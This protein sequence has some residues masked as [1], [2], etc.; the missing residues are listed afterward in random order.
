MIKK[1]YR[2]NVVILDDSDSIYYYQNLTFDPSFR[3]GVAGQSSTVAFLNRNYDVGMFRLLK[4]RL[5]I[6]HTGL[7]VGLHT[8]L[9][10]PFSEKIS[11]LKQGGFFEY[12][13]SFWILPRYLNPEVPKDLPEVLTMDHL[14]IGFYICC[15]PLFSAMISFVFETQI[16]VRAS[17]ASY[18]VLKNSVKII[19]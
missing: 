9:V 10:E 11:K 8:V 13:I 19:N 5:I 4:E 15:I 7:D 18:Y 2:A 12:W 14:A 3:G 16:Y 6:E 17:I 1:I